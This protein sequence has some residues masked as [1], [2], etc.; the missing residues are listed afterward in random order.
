MAAARSP[1]VAPAGSSRVEPR[2]VSRISSCRRV[3]ISPMI[4]T[5]LD[6]EKMGSDRHPEK[7]DGP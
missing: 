6:D 3:G 4:G 2:G 5:V 7:G 1:T